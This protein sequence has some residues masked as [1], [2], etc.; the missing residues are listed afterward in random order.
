ME[1]LKSHFVKNHILDTGYSPEQWK[2]PGCLGYIGGE[3]YY[4]VIWA[5]IS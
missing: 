1:L 4:P 3:L 2:K 5:I